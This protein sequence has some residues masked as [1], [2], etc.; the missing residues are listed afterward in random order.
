MITNNPIVALVYDFD[1]TLS[2]GNMQEFG[3]IRAL[4]QDAK[5]FW[6]KNTKM[7][8]ENDATINY[9]FLCLR[10]GHFREGFQ[11]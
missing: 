4:G 8:V 5:E 7:S 3:F 11:N 6:K 9:H 10:D 1:G 2:P